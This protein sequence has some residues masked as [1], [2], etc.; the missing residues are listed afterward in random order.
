MLEF[1]IY[2]L[3]EE[4]VQAERLLG[5]NARKM[6]VLAEAEDFKNHR[7]L[8]EKI[9]G[10]VEYDLQADTAVLTLSPQE[11]INLSSEIEQCEH[12]LLFGISPT[13]I[14]L[15]VNLKKRLIQLERLTIVRSGPLGKVASDTNE[16]RALW[17]VLKSVFK[18]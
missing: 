14:G 15:N 11:R 17:Q 9:L 13:Q 4:V 8:L 3:P 10:A 16:K 12:L 6:L 1:R 5:N 18:S 2:A 7:D